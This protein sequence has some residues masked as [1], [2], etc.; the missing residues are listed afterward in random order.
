MQWRCFA[1]VAES[2]TACRHAQ[3]KRKPL[4]FVDDLLYL[5][6]DEAHEAWANALGLDVHKLALGH[7]NGF[8]HC[9]CKPH[10]GFFAGAFLAA[11]GFQ[12]IRTAVRIYAFTY[13]WGTVFF[14]LV[15][16]GPKEG[17]LL[18]SWGVGAAFVVYLGVLLVGKDFYY[19]GVAAGVVALTD[20]AA[21]CARAF[22][23]EYV[24][25]LVGVG[26]AALPTGLAVH[27]LAVEG[28]LVEVDG[29]GSGHGWKLHN[30]AFHLF[31]PL[32]EVGQVYFN[33]HA[34]LGWGVEQGGE[35]NSI[36]QG[37]AF[38][39]LYKVG[40]FFAKEA[41][42]DARIKAESEGHFL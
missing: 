8:G 41:C 9:H 32:G 29:S 22:A 20:G 37:V 31:L 42:F 16:H 21:Q 23:D 26:L 19:G 35:C 12:L 11:V 27:A 14:G 17:A 2:P 10:V 5:D 13:S 33:V 28:L 18:G 6:F 4:H 34:L 15:V 1:I 7:G 3:K 30:R 39:G 25:A 40:V 38:G 36:G 24:A